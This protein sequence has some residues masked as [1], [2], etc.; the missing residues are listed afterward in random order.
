M[1]N[2]TLFKVA[3]ALFKLVRT[4]IV[5]A[6][7]HWL[8]HT[9]NKCKQVE[10]WS[11]SNW[12]RTLNAIWPS[13][14]N[15]CIGENMFLRPKSANCLACALV[16]PWLMWPWRVRMRKLLLMIS[17][18]FVSVL[19]KQ[20]KS[21]AFCVCSAKTKQKQCC[22]A[23]CRWSMGRSSFLLR[24]EQNKHNPT[25]IGILQNSFWLSWIISFVQIAKQITSS[26]RQCGLWRHILTQ[27]HRV[28]R[29]VD[30]C[31]LLSTAL[32]AE[33]LPKDRFLFANWTNS[34]VCWSTGQS[35]Q[36]PGHVVPLVM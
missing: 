15:C 18:D 4:R 8:L 11:K 6:G 31:F 29:K 10:R 34:N 3:R 19:P 26:F 12:E 25:I 17:W 2:T 13:I 7:R 28:E 32:T 22:C 33:T 21:N 27:W 24:S 5:M 30:S 35:S 36:C 1:E 9:W 23:S 16:E 20:Y 14:P